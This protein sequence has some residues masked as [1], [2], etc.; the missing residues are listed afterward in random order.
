MT[1][2]NF[3]KESK[4][5]LKAAVV[6]IRPK[7]CLYI[8][9][10]KYYRRVCFFFISNLHEHLMYSLDLKTVDK[11]VYRRKNSSAQAKAGHDELAKILSRSAG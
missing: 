10:Y 11:V 6:T 2:R 9:L 3:S 7:L 4:L 8:N 1:D 5:R